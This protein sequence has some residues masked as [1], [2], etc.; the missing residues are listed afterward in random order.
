[1]IFHS[2]NIW[3]CKKALLVALVL[4]VGEMGFPHAGMAAV[5]D[6]KEQ[7]P[8]ESIEAFLIPDPQ[9]E[10]QALALAQSET[11][12]VPVDDPEIKRLPVI[13]DRA[14]SKVLHVTVTAYASV[15]EL[16]DDDPFTM[17]DGMRVFDG[18]V[19]TNVLPFGTQV[20]FPDVFG[21]KVFEVHDRMNTRYN[22]KYIIDIWH[23][24]KQAAKKFGAKHAVRMEILE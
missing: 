5:F 2:R 17:A 24:A 1:M 13:A 7:R 18:A 10:A 9:A 6:D 4:L 21:D 15:P 14:V 19:A 8:L 11:P 16:T 20:R 3:R 12:E 23:P 22:G